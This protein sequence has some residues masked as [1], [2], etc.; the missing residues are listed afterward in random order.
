MNYLMDVYAQFYLILC[1]TEY[2]SAVPFHRYRT[3]WLVGKHADVRTCVRSHVRTAS[4][5]MDT[6]TASSLLGA[7][8]LQNVNLLN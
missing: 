7:I 2:N 5:R 3:S 1:Y 8:L 4:N 6:G